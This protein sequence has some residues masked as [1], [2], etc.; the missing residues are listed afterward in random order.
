[1]AIGIDGHIEERI[2]ALY[3]CRPFELFLLTGQP[4]AHSL[5]QGRRAFISA[6][7]FHSFKPDVVRGLLT[8]AKPV[9][10]ENSI[11]IKRSSGSRDLEICDLATGTTSLFPLGALGH[12]VRD[13]L[14]FD[15]REAP[16]A[17]GDA[18]NKFLPSTKA[19]NKPAA[20]PGFSLK[21]KL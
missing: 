6:R 9:N 12:K 15:D 16:P 11:A 1:M 19:D 10:I 21:L 5:G 8:I 4:R 3:V 17:Y 20:A 13:L 7:P 2:E 18:W 14:A